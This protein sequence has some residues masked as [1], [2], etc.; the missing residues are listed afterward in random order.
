MMLRGLA[1]RAGI[2]LVL[3]SLLLPWVGARALIVDAIGDSKNTEA[4]DDDPG[5]A[6]VGRCRSWTAVYLGGGWVLTARHVGAADLN[7]DGEKYTAVPNSRQVISVL[8]EAK[9]DLIL[10][11]IDPL[12]ALP[13]LS[14]SKSPPEIGESILMIGAGYGRG[15]QITGGYFSGYYW[16]SK[17]GMKWGTG[18]VFEYLVAET[19]GTTKAFATRF[20]I[21]K[22]RYEAQAASGDSGGAAFVRGADRWELAGILLAIKGYDGQ[23]QRSAVYGNQT[24]I[25]DLA[26]YRETI[27]RV[28]G[29]SED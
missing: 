21:A 5:W 4:P 24:V 12:P 22:T 15:D 26:H 16:D 25:A 8:G 13:T 11:R 10:F 23:P 18:T 27:Y 9:T 3:V 19:V 14:L 6:N 28:T 17:I 7:L 20:S 2:A 1:S 29:R